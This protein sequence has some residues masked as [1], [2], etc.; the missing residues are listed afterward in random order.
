MVTF[1]AKDIY[2]DAVTSQRIKLAL[3]AQFAKTCFR[4]MP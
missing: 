2:I 1:I 3:T 4:H